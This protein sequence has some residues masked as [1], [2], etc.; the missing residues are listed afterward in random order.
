MFTNT[1][2]LVQTPPTS[3][4]DL[5][6]LDICCC[7][8]FHRALTPQRHINKADKKL[9]RKGKDGILAVGAFTP[10]LKFEESVTISMIVISLD[11][12]SNKE[13]EQSVFYGVTQ[14]QY[15]QGVTV[16]DY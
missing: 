6:L 5:P 4:A 9:M 12:F 15:K 8:C 13:L 11:N 2:H 14:W 7:S 10:G 1:A 16:L 3:S